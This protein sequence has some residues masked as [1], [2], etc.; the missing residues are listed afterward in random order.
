LKDQA[1]E[2]NKPT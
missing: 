2:E 1:K